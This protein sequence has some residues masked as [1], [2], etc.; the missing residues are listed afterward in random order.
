MNKMEQMMHKVVNVT[1]FNR[2]FL[3][4]FFLGIS[5]ASYTQNKLNGKYSNLM[6][7]QEHFNYIIFNEDKKFEYHKGASLGD[8]YYGRGNY[9]I[10]DDQLILNYNL[11]QP[12][13][14]GVHDLS[15]WNN[16]KDSIEIHFAIKDLNDIPLKGINIINLDIKDGVQ[17]DSNGFAVFKLPKVN[18]D[19][20]ISC[21]QVGY[22]HYKFYINGNNNYQAN[23]T[24]IHNKGIT[25]TPILNQVDTL[26]LKE[27]KE[28]YFI[29]LLK[30]GKEE[31]WRKI[32]Y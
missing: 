6:L 4:L 9:S 8:D 2:T 10:K 7:M 17:T 11:T 22:L 20:K 19:Y 23:V 13:I 18:K 32:K 26:K 29:V 28:D 30:N 31:K 12:K 27:I 15:L 24:L 16:N 3:L 21:S 25:G 14:T 5:I 1:N